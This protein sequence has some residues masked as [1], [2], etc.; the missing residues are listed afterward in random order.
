LTEFLS[1]RGMAERVPSGCKLGLAPD[2]S[3]ASPGIVRHLIDCGVRDLH[4]ICAP[5]GGMQVDML[6]GAGAVATVETSA[7]SLGEVGA[8]PC[9]TRAAKEGSIRILDATCPAVFA[10]LTAAQKGVPFMPMRGILGTDIL[11]SR[12][13]WKVIANPF[14]ERDPL[15]AVSAIQPDIS[16]IHVSEAD[17][18]GNV[19]VGRRRELMLLA[20]A[21]KK[22]F[23]SAEHISEISLLEDERT[24]AGVLPAMYVTAIAE[25]KNGA[26]PTGLYAEYPSDD[27][28]VAQYARSARTREGFQEYLRD[29]WRL[30]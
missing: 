21:S 18:F 5:I 28:E 20:Y 2:A 16:L 29:R 27:I 3:G 23:V 19:R 6:I 11:K 24:A 7:V 15:V 4:V 12:T 26:W 8:A 25:L 1:P 9:F 13:D 10:G 17:R 22:V 14:D 30:N